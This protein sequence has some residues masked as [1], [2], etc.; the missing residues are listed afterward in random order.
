MTEKQPAVYILANKPNGTLYVGVTSQ[1]IQRV[2]QHKNHVV[3]GFTGK[4]S[5][6]L[7]VYYEMHTDMAEVIM[8]EKRIKRWRRVWKIELIETFNP[9]WR[10]LYDDLI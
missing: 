2:W 7:L 9:A 5:V 1:L 3:E 6:N 10:D 4:Y 8:R